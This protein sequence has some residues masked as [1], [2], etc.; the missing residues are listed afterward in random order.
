M[1]NGTFGSLPAV[2][3]EGR[4]WAGT[5]AGRTDLA[6]AVGGSPGEPDSAVGMHSAD[7]VCTERWEV[8]M[9]SRFDRSHKKSD[10]PV[11]S[12]SDRTY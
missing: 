4:G 9:Q 3:P 1:E 11:D 8:I 10:C 6:V 5:W 12:P 2:A 7:L